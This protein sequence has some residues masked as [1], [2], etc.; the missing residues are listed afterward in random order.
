MVNHYVWIGN[1][2]SENIVFRL[3]AS[4]ETGHVWAYIE[5]TALQLVA[6]KSVQ[7]KRFREK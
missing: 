4:S 1:S 5:C 7:R 2:F 3:G 6:A